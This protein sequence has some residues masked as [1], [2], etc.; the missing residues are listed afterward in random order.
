MINE[1]I[2]NRELLKIYQKIYDLYYSDFLYEIFLNK[3]DDIICEDV[4][5]IL[6]FNEFMKSELF[7]KYHNIYYRKEKLKRIVK[8][9]D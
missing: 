7:K 3:F 4:S 9:N 8:D 1:L 6:T 5:D 2:K